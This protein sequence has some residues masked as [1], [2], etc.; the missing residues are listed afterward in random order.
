MR[1][2]LLELVRQESGVTSV[3]V[4]THNVDFVFIQSLVLSALRKCGHPSL[5][6]FGD[7]DCAAESF[8]RQ[9]AV[10]SGLGTRY[11]VVPV[12][13]EPG[14]RF[15]PKA[16]LLSGPAK[17]TLLVGSGNLTFGGWR[18]NAEVWTRFDTGVDGTGPFTFFRSYL[19]EVLAHLPLSE[20]VTAQ[21]D[22]AFDPGI[23]PWA[24]DMAP[25]SGLLGRAHGGQ[26]L[27]DQVV[28]TAGGAPASKLVVCSP[29]FDDE[30]KALT[31]FSAAL[32][33]DQVEV[34]VQ[35]DECGIHQEAAAHL[36]ERAQL[37]PVKV[38]SRSEDGKEHSRFIH[39]KLYAIERA[40]DVLVFAGS[41][42]CTWAALLAEGARGNAELLAVRSMTSEEARDQL[43]G[44]LTLLEGQPELHAK[45]N[46]LETPA[47]PKPLRVLAAR[48]DAG[49]LTIAFACAPSVEVTACLLDE[50]RVPV[51]RVGPASVAA[52]VATLP[53]EVV[54][55]GEL[56]GDVY[57]SPAHWVDDEHSLRVTSTEREV[58]RQV[59]RNISAGTWNAEAW[60]ETLEAILRNLKYMPA[61][62]SKVR[63]AP[64]AQ[65]EPKPRSPYTWDDVFSNAYRLP[66]GLSQMFGLL[67]GGREQGLRD[68]LLRWFGIADLA[69]AN[70]TETPS[71]PPDDEGVPE[72]VPK[73]GAPTEPERKPGE[74][75]DKEL[76]ERQRRRVIRVATGVKQ[77]MTSKSYLEARAPEQLARDIG[78]V[79][80]LLRE[81]L[82][83]GWLL[84]SEFL[85]ITKDI[86]TALFFSSEADSTRGWIEVRSA[87]HGDDEDFIGRIASVEV[88]AALALWALE[89]EGQPQS[90][91]RTL[92][93]LAAVVSVARLPW[94]WLAGDPYAISAELSKALTFTHRGQADGREVNY[95]GRWLQL[96]RRGR[97]LGAL[98]GLLVSLTM[99]E[100]RQRAPWRRLTPGEL[101]WQGRRG[102]CLTTTPCQMVR[103]R[104]YEV[105]C[106]QSTGAT[107]KLRAEG[108]LPLRSVV[109]ASAGWSE[110][111]LEA[112]MHEQLADLLDLVAG[113]TPAA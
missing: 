5:T 26:S 100:L 36:P 57:H 46:E 70:L 7:A 53:R 28:A 98:E 12:L 76:R 16:V 66:V 105:F 51:T 44:E 10:L 52:R 63:G 91:E 34:L 32:G 103:G 8:A 18:E 92:T 60:A 81:A 104:S 68:L 93:H 30:L 79:S 41:A 69:A 110:G 27:L 42:N 35:A 78:I 20:E 88:S 45:G 39:A 22:E 23:H 61:P 13:M 85:S 37:L 1:A 106:L 90:P 94:L 29:Y 74:P 24:V 14:F 97:A 111:T 95:E 77:T 2:D 6:I 48:F 9:G 72:P 43:L 82:S 87:A 83:Q 89:V 96:I 55:V 84:P 73:Q 56:A 33:T 101:L 109:E 112:A 58:A 113:T 21:V 99:D 65:Q 3:V 71:P 49:Q 107:I 102:F 59:D 75:G 54:L 17:A 15:H 47:D 64:G 11:R 25:P 19:G 50:I 108:M 80:P 86:W 67:G 38:L 62:R 31:R 4:L 40:A